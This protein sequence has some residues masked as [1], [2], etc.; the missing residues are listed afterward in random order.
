[1]T[2]WEAVIIGFGGGFVP[3]QGSERVGEIR[4]WDDEL[5][6]E[7]EMRNESTEVDREK[8]RR[9][10]KVA[11]RSVLGGTLLLW[12][13]S[14]VHARNFGDGKRIRSTAIYIPLTRRTMNRTPHACISILASL[15]A[16]RRRMEQDGRGYD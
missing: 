6:F 2:V 12:P 14:P 11:N 3:L 5:G 9:S 7:V 8:R 15:G 4:L 1:M 10:G 13:T 16:S